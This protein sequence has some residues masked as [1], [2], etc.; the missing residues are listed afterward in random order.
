MQASEE[1]EQQAHRCKIRDYRQ[2]RGSVRLG[3]NQRNRGKGNQLQA[4]EPRG[5]RSPNTKE[6]R[7]KLLV[8]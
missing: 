2:V 8:F 5:R 6:A 1:T 7:N 4:S 3:M